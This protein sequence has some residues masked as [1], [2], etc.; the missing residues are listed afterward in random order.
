MVR[1]LALLLCLSIHLVA[2]DNPAAKAAR[3]WRMDHEKAIV[4]EFVALLSIP[5]VSSDHANVQRN[6]DA[7]VQMLS[8]RGVAARTVTVPGANPVVYG[9]LENPVATRT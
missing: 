2:Q 9:E 5:N 6:A 4:T 7:I 1:V 8:R 3:A